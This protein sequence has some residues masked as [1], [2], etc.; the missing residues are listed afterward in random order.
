MTLCLRNSSFSKTRLLKVLE[1]VTLNWFQQHWPLVFLR[2]RAFPE[3][4]PILSE[5]PEMEK[6]SRPFFLQIVGDR[7]T[8]EEMLVNLS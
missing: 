5:D 8:S 1:I 6:S 7:D 2:D 3:T 4:V